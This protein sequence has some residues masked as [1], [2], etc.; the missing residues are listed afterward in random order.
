MQAQRQINIPEAFQDLFRPY[1]YKVYYGGRDGAK[2]FAFADALL[3]Q[4]AIKPLR[5]L[6]T[7]ELQSSIADSV[8]KLLCD[9]ITRL[10]LSHLYDIQKNA[11][12]SKCGSLFLFK[13]L[14]FNIQ[15][16]K[17]TE[18]VDIC[19]VEEAQAVTH[20]SWQVLIP[21]IRKPGSQIWL[22]F[23]TGEADDPT[24]VR[25]VTNTPPNAIVRKVSF[26]DNPYHS[27]V[28][29]QERLYLQRVDPDAYEHVWEG[30]PL[31][32]SDACIFKGKFVI[33]AFEAP[34]NVGRFYYGADWGFSQ[35]PTALTRSFVQDR[36]LFITDEAYGVGVELDEIE[37]LFDTVPGSRE[38]P[39]NA[40]DSRPETISY[41]K[42]KDFESVVSRNRGSMTMPRPI[43]RAQSKRAL[44]I[45][46][47]SSRSSSIRAADI[48]R[49]NSNSTAIRRTNSPEKCCPSSL[50][51]ITTA[52]L[53]MCA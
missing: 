32:I 12:M 50:M 41:V 4:A 25:F 26:R 16:I 31:S 10:D 6:C 18:G 42:K 2:S 45:F 13:G 14:R 3:S 19:W 8:Y 40:D 53:E 51:L 29:E 15:E 43:R 20:T 30:E 38:W 37:E 24:Y 17:S 34:E 21:T 36:K 46:G 48:P 1:R 27:D 22:S 5:I 52:S 11:I 39:I 7:R 28:M 35:D 44:P 9:E 47:S 49:M 23:N 33:E